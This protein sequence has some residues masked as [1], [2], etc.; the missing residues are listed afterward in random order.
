MDGTEIIFW[1]AVATVFYTYA[2]YPLLVAAAAWLKQGAPD[3]PFLDDGEMPTVTLLI[4]AHNEERWIGRKIENTLRLGYPRDRMEIVVASDGSTDK[5]VEIA[6]GYSSRGI[7]V[8]P[9]PSRRGKI[10][11]V[12]QVTPSLRGEIV[13]ISDVTAMLEPDSLRLLARHFRDPGVGCV[14]GDRLS[15]ETESRATEGEGFYWRYEGW[16]KRSE[17]RYFSCLGGYGQILAIRRDLLTQFLPLI[18]DDF[19]S[20]MKIL[21]ETGA[22]TVFEPQAIARIPAASTLLQ[23]FKRKSRTHAVLLMELPSLKK[24]LNPS[25]SGVWWQF[26]S[27]HILRLF[28]PW[29]MAAAFVSSAL[30]WNAGFIYRAALC[31]QAAFYALAAMGYLLVKRGTS[32]KPA[33]FCFYFVLANAALAHA[34]LRWLRWLRQGRLTLWE[35]TDR[36]LPQAAPANGTQKRGPG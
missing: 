17:S 36:T 4:P 18:S 8:I 35:R 20:P 21:I 12:N 6:S 10:A 13:L 32:W 25:K 34:W 11:I 22:R 28:V 31:A 23:E 14:A 33:Y 2:G 19:Y 29:A 16:L 1:V 24:G 5:T 26:W 9:T 30:L 27:H 3:P 15:V 7:A